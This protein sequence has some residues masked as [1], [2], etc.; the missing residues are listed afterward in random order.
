MQRLYRILH[1]LL[2]RQSDGNGIQHIAT[3]AQLEKRPC[4]AMKSAYG[5]P[6]D[7]HFWSGWPGAYCIKC[8]AE[9]KDE[10]CLGD[11]CEC[12]CHAELW[13]SYEQA[14]DKAS[15]LDLLGRCY[16]TMNRPQ[17]PDAALMDQVFAALRHFGRIED[18]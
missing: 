14:E 13:K 4:P 5:E 1:K 16:D 3:C 2:G 10:A 15:L 6:S 8:H 9:D 11:L 17:K 7:E 12:P 18:R